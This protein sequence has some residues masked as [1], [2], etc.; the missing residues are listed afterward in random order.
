MKK[1]EK[2]LENNEAVVDK[3]KNKAEKNSK[4]AAVKL[5]KKMDGFCVIGL[6]RFGRTVALALSNEGHEVLAIDNNEKNVHSIEKYVE[7][8]AIADSTAPEVLHNLGVQNFD[9]VVICI[10]QDLQASVVTTLICKKLGVKL[11]VARASTEE[12]KE[13]LERVGADVVVFPEDYTAHKVAK[14]LSNPSMNDVISLTEKFK[15]VEMATPDDWTD[16]S[17]LEL[18]T[19]KKFHITIIVI[20]RQ[21]FIIYPEP[22]TE[23]KKGDTLI[24]AGDKKKLAELSGKSSDV[25]DVL[26]ALSSGLRFD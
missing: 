10:G 14:M 7:G 8:T 9:C 16:K 17:L 19:R 18:D 23:L 13:I 21:D 12:Q 20:K 15:I 3:I 25:I 26:H 22:E 1:E 2:Q 24:V 6:G 5:K 4:D 11:I